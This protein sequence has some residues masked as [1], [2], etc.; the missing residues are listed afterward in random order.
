MTFDEVMQELEAAGT[1]Q[2][3]KIYKRHGAGDVLFGVSYANL[4]KLQKKIKLD[5]ALAKQLWATGNF[6]ARNLA[7]KIADPR[8]ADAAL[9][10]SWAKDLTSQLLTDDFTS[11]ASQT[12]F[13][14]QHQKMLEWMPSEN[15]WLVRT[16]WQLLTSLLNDKTLP[17]SFFEPYLEILERT[18]HTAPNWVR[19]AMNNTLINMGLRSSALKEKAL[20]AAALI[21]KVEVDH[22]ETSC[23]TPDAASY[24]LKTLEYR[25][26]KAEQAAAKV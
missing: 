22:G 15:E 19:H 4:G 21:G 13:E 14:L 6:D 11:Y 25:A 18:I 5:H 2:N 7:V 1:E 17:D 24:I 3:R 16:A 20:A 26:K 8:Q 12:S 9:F 10:D 23:K